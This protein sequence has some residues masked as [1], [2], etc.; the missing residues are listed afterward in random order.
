MVMYYNKRGTS[1]ERIRMAKFTAY[2]PDDL[3]DA[4]RAGRPSQNPSQLVQEGLRALV[5]STGTRPS[6]ARAV[7]GD[8]D[9][10]VAALVPRLAEQAERAFQTGYREA[11][12]FAR[13]QLES[14]RGDWAWVNL[15]ELADVDWNVT[16]WIKRGGDEP[17][18]VSFYLEKDP[19]WARA[20]GTPDMPV[21]SGAE[22]MGFVEA[23]RTV[24]AQVRE[25]EPGIG[26]GDA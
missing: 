3:W 7:P 11:L 26:A 8:A 20:M 23:L 16:E 18:L 21:L 12:E 14:K 25:G 9:E 4:A 2:V 15:E 6:F 5:A 13:W 24:W 22:M 19:G 1:Q 17:V 10:A